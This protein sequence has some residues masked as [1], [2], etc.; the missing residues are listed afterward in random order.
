MSLLEMTGIITFAAV[1]A[2]QAMQKHMDLFGVYILAITTA[3][4]GG[5]IRDVVMDRGTPLF[6]SNNTMLVTALIS[7]TAIVLLRKQFQ[8]NVF[9]VTLDAL[10]LGVFAVDAGMKA[11]ASSYTFAGYLFV[12]LMT[13]IGGGILKDLLSGELPAV[14][15]K[16]VYAVAA[17]VGI[18]FMWFAYPFIGIQLSSYISVVLIFATR[19]FCYLNNINLPV[20]KIK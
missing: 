14:L 2:Y 1:G 13:G 10:G 17:L 11:I 12:A 18:V 16:D 6:F 20:V 7:A 15:H 9:V 5:I 3:A 19:M 8:L 4:G